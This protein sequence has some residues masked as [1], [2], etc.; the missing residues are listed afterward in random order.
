MMS[1]AQARD[2]ALELV[3]QGGYDGTIARNVE[4]P[5]RVGRCKNEVVKVKPTITET[6]LVVE[7]K[8]GTGVKTGRD[9]FTLDVKRKGIVSSVGSGMP[10]DL[11]T[12][13]AG[14]KVKIEFL[15]ITADGK[16]REPRFKGI[17]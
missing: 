13:K 6:L 2:W 11:G 17:A 14:S 10:H 16:L 3:S 5:Y 7:V 1:L 4:A 8:T 15:G 9:V 12:L